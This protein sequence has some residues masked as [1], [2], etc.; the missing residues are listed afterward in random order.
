MPLR[1]KCALIGLAA[2]AGLLGLAMPGIAAAGGDTSTQTLV[3][4]P[5]QGFAPLY[6]LVRSARSSIDM[7]MYELA[8]TKMQDLLC[9][10]AKNG[11]AVRVILDQNEEYAHNLVAYD[12]LKG[13]GVHVVWAWRK[14]EATHQKTIVVDHA[15]AAIMSLNLASRYYSDTRDYAVI[16]RDPRDVA[17]IED[18]FDADFRHAPIIPPV[19]DDLVW[20]PTNSKTE[21]LD[22]ID[23]A[24]TSLLIENEEMRYGV[25]VNALEQAARRGVD[26]SVCMND[27]SD[28]AAAFDALKKAGVKIRTYIPDDPIYIHAKAIVAD[29]GTPAARAFVGSENFSSASLNHNRELGLIT[30]R[31]TVVS[32]LYATMRKDYAGGTP[33]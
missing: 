17:A 29:Y 6:D 18:T 23:S 25:I 9:R 21:L 16:D 28:Y 8:D 1:R 14:Y 10:A 27:E 24:R 7:T 33:W 30:T 13:C 3:V 2:L 31:P 20:S 26:V 19:G 22:I 5:D 15:T 11:V 4:E 32:R 12:Q